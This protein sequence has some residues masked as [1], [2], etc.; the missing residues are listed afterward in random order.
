M[1]MVTVRNALTGK[2]ECHYRMQL[3]SMT[4]LQLNA[5]EA[6]GQTGADQKLMDGLVDIVNTYSKRTHCRTV[7][8]VSYLLIKLIKAFIKH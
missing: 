2:F 1:E 4:S 5:T 8:W 6:K 3:L 7:N